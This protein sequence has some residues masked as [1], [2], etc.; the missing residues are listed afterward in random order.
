MANGDAAAA[1]GMAV[2]V[3]T[4]DLRMAYDEE[5]KGRDYLAAHQT[6]GTHPASAINS[7]VLD[8][9]RIPNLDA[10]K[11]TSG[12]IDRPVTT[13][14]VVQGGILS[15]GTTGKGFSAAGDAYAFNVIVDAAVSVGGQIVNPTAYGSVVS[16]G[17]TLA[18]RS[19]GTFGYFP[20]ARRFKK[21]IKPADIDPDALLDER[22][23]PREYDWKAEYGGGHDYGLI[24]EDVAAVFPWLAY[25]GDEDGVVDGYDKAGLVLPLI[26]TVRHL[27]AR[28]AELEA[29]VAGQ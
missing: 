18:V 2:V 16:S 13:S 23:Q 9:A 26:A 3:G 22:L 1:A 21:N 6:S 28:V 14:G 10:S 29:K 20:S 27:A 19:D 24:A 4:A 25:D 15:V 8:V 11:I 17:R 7:G 12:T 5:N